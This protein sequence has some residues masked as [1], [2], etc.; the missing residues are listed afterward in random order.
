MGQTLSEP[1]TTKDTSTCSNHL[2]KVASSC[3]QGWRINMEDAHTHLLSL[4]GDKEASFFGVY[5]GHGGARVAEYSANHLHRKILSQPEYS[6]GNIEEAIRKGFLALDQEMSQ[7]ETMKEELAGTTC[8]CTLIKDNKL[9]CGN[10]GD[11]R[12]IASVRG[13]VDFSSMDHKP[14]N[15]LE[16]KRI[17]A[18]GGW[19]EFNRVNGNLALSRALG[20]FVFK[21]NSEKSAEEQIVTANPDVT[22]YEITQDLEFTVLA[23]DGIWDVLTNQEVVDFVR[24]R[25]AQRVEPDVICEDLLTRCLAPAPEV[26]GLGCDNMTAILVCFLHGG[27]YEDLVLKC[28]RPRLP[29]VGE[30]NSDSSTL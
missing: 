10:A 8:I 21:K 12:V 22:V 17:I 30:Q 5:D 25:I 20:D 18:A 3:M 2:Y 23:C 19:V 1:V 13:K 16:T 28:S 6:Q 26:G 7:D 14:C 9:Y 4:P 24:S 11:S 27:T 29:D 15:E